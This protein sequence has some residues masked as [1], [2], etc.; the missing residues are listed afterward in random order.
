MV[1]DP[2]RVVRTFSPILKCVDENKLRMLG[3]GE[4][5]SHS[6][7][8]LSGT[9]GPLFPYPGLFKIIVQV[10]WEVNG[11][12]TRVLGENSV[13]VTPPHAEEHASAAQQLLSTP[14]VLFVLSIGGDHLKDG[15][16]AIQR[17][18]N[19]VLKPHFAF[20]EAKR[21]GTRF[22]KRN[23]ELEKA[24]AL[25][26]ESTIM[27]SAEIKRAAKLIG[28]GNIALPEDIVKGLPK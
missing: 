20:I 14:D 22:G 26:D 5:I 24:I 15:I 1:I 7:T 2:A 16:D 8:L 18:D 6:V 25:L 4:T 10:L 21:I 12:Q 9:E 19:K 27:S 13:M 17:L 28:A 11:I 3:P 23:A